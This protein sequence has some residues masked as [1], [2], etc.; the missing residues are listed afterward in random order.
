MKQIIP[1]S[2]REIVIAWAVAWVTN[3]IIG[4]AITE[5]N[6]VMVAWLL[7]LS[8]ICA[9]FL[10]YVL[11]WRVFVVPSWHWFRK[12]VTGTFFERIIFTN[13]KEKKQ[14]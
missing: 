1:F 6:S 2:T 7:L 9:V 5:E 4:M 11:M 10:T 12:A 3:T 14:K 13:A 8:L